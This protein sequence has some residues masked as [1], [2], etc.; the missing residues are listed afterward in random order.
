MEWTFGRDDRAPRDNRQR[1]HA[2]R[3]Y[4]VG[5]DPAVLEGDDTE[6]GDDND[7][8]EDVGVFVNEVYGLNVSPKQWAAKM[9]TEKRKEEAHWA[10]PVRMALHTALLAMRSRRFKSN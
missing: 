6:K 8:N 1:E 4:A 7:Q 10:A 3:W 5:G 9:E 2:K